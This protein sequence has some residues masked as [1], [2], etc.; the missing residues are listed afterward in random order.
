[1]RLLKPWSSFWFMP[2][3][4]VILIITYLLSFGN[5]LGWIQLISWHFWVYFVDLCSSFCAWKLNAN[6]NLMQTGEVSYDTCSWFG[7]TEIAIWRMWSF[8][9]FV[10]SIVWHSPS[11]VYFWLYMYRT[12]RHQ[13]HWN[14]SNQGKHFQSIDLQPIQV[15]M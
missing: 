6:N 3:N 13:R 7:E 15:S 9:C 2:Y 8:L 4:P 1:V 12:R 10:S 11:N 5:W 14:L